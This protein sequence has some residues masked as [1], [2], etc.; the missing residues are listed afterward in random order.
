M[1]STNIN[2]SNEY[3]RR[4]NAVL[5]HLDQHYASEQG[6]ETLAGI[7]NFSPF[8]FHRIFKAILGESLY[9]DIQHIRIEKAAH[10]LKFQ[11]QK[12]ITAIAL[13]CGFNSSAAFARTFKEYFAMSAT[14]WRKNS[15][16]SM[17]IDPETNH[18]QWNLDMLSRKN[19]TIE[20]SDLP[21]VQLAYLRHIGPLKG[22]K[23]VGQT[24]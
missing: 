14:A 10:Q 22:Q 2:Q 24:V 15:I 9:K 18:A 20:V 4:I 16:A 8:H 13:D 23:K 1:E 12:S 17:Y 11:Q 21:E 7:A 19:V 6:L 3:K 5:D